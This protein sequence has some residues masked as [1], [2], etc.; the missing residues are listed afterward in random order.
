MMGL[1]FPEDQ[2]HFVRR[3]RE[4]RHAANRL[5]YRATQLLPRTWRRKTRRWLFFDNRR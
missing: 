1:L 2:R 3:W 4:L 5:T